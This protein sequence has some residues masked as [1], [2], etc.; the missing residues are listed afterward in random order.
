MTSSNAKY[1]KRVL[2]RVFGATPESIVKIMAV[3]K[4]EGN[5]TLITDGNVK[6]A[7]SSKQLAQLNNLLKSETKEEELSGETAGDDTQQADEASMGGSSDVSTSQKVNEAKAENPTKGMKKCWTSDCGGASVYNNREWNEY[8]CKMK[9]GSTA[10]CDSKQDAIDTAKAQLKH[11]DK[12]KNKKSIKEGFSFKHYLINE[13]T[14]TFDDY[15][16]SAIANRD[17]G[18]GK[19]V[20][21]ENR[22]KGV[23]PTASKS[24][25]ARK[26]LQMAQ[27][28][29]QKKAAQGL[30]AVAMENEKNEKAAGKT[31]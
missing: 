5:G 3:L 29:A 11:A 17:S 6:R 16:M 8:I 1:F 19:Q 12:N 15:A 4:A 7:L 25:A 21:R 18:S 9:D 28:P 13:N 23:T 26:A 24:M 10:H 20:E 2:S 27:T 22:A 30:L 31:S 14:G